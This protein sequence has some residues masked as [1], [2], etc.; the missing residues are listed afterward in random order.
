[1]KWFLVIMLAVTFFGGVGG[2][3]YLFSTAPSGQEGAGAA[4]AALFLSAVGV[5]AGFFEVCLIGQEIE[6]EN[7]EN[8]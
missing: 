5:V 6:K 2:G 4:L 1:M 8:V 7:R 3:A